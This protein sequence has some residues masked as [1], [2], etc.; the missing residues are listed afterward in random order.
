MDNGVNSRLQGILSGLSGNKMS[1]LERL[2]SSPE[3]QNLIKSLSPQDK[4]AIIERFMSLDKSAIEKSL[5]NIDSA[6]L[7]GMSA[8]DI[9]S[10]LR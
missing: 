9:L 7:S 4:K 1:E 2:M 10:K 8:K 5:K 3:G 6:S